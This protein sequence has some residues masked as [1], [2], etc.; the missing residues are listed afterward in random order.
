MANVVGFGIAAL[1]VGSLASDDL[2]RAVFRIL[3]S[4]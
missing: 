4:S 2:L 3:D 1:V